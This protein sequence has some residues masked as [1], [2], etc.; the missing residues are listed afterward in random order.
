M[1]ERPRQQKPFRPLDG[2]KLIDLVPYSLRV[3]GM[4][5]VEVEGPGAAAQSLSFSTLMGE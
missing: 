2:L 5:E 3:I 4:V 1:I